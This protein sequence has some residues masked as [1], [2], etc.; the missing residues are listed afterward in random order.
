MGSVDPSTFNVLTILISAFVTFMVGGIWYAALFA[1]SWAK[2]NKFSEE[3]L[4][5]ANQPV[6]FGGSFVL[7]LLSA[8]ILAFFI[9]T[10]ADLAFGT[11]AGLMVGL[12]VSFA[13]GINYLF[14]MR[15]F[16][17]FLI[18]AAYNVVTF[19]IMGA[20]IGAWL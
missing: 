18:N 15:S 2:E 14:E 7:S 10:D 11:F 19:T 12:W 16:K 5:K 8:I 20:I 9:G 17:L 13:F 6:I 1:K 4:K 3:D